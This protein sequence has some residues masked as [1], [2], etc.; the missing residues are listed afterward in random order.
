MSKFTPSVHEKPS[1]YF[2]VKEEKQYKLRIMSEI[3]DGFFGWTEVL[4]E[5]KKKRKPLRFK[6]LK[7]ANQVEFSHGKYDDPSKPVIPK[8]FW[9][10]IVWNYEL[11]IFQVWEITQKGIM[12]QL[13]SLANHSDW[14]DFKNY[15]LTIERINNQPVEYPILSSPSKPVSKEISSAFKKLKYNLEL[16]YDGGHPI[17]GVKKDKEESAAVEPAF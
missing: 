5:G 8:Q 1:E 11:E 10:T 9:A 14:G 17:S 15:D 13:D 2:N 3:I 7:E 16:L 6:T 12:K 4:V